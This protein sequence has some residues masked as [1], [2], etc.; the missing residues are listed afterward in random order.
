MTF[1]DETLLAYLE[2]TL[3][4]VQSRAIEAAVEEDVEVEKLWALFRVDFF[5]AMT[6]RPLL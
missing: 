4:E 6:I 5:F 1:S 2:G 3:D